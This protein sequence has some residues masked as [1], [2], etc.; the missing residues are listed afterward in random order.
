MEDGGWSNKEWPPDGAP[1]PWVRLIAHFPVV[2]QLVHSKPLHNTICT[3]GF[4]FKSCFLWGSVFTCALSKHLAEASAV[5]IF[6]PFLYI[7]RKEK[8]LG[9]W[10]WDW[11]IGWLK[12]D[13]WDWLIE[14]IWD[15]LIEV[16]ILIYGS[17]NA[18]ICFHICRQ[19]LYNQTLITNRGKWL[20]SGRKSFCKDVCDLLSPPPN[21]NHQLK[22]LFWEN[23]GG[24]MGVKKKSLQIMDFVNR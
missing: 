17:V 24:E 9:I 14:I 22:S 19:S 11:L 21:Y 2:V 12:V 10:M 8:G 4:R 6:A 15:W 1:V 20:P 16:K 13:W 23:A 18:Y 7:L 5:K 3:H